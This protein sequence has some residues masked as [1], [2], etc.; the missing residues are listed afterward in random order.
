MTRTGDYEVSLAE[1]ANICHNRGAHIFMSIHNNAHTNRIYSGTETY[2][3]NRG[4][5]DASSRRLATLVQQ[6]L[7]SPF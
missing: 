6:E 5:N 4:A 2:Y 3:Y 1:R 7:V